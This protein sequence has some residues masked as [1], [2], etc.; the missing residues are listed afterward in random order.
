MRIDLSEPNTSYHNSFVT[1]RLNTPLLLSTGVRTI[2]LIE[3]RGKWANIAA[4]TI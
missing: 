1:S 2:D 3:R 4:S